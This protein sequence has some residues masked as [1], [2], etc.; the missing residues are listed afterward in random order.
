MDRRGVTGIL[1]DIQSSSYHSYNSTHIEDCYNY[2]SR[3]YT[4]SEDYTI[5]PTT[6]YPTAI[7]T[8]EYAPFYNYHNEVGTNNQNDTNE[9]SVSEMNSRRK[10]QYQYFGWEGYNRSKLT[11]FHFGIETSDLSR[12]YFT[13]NCSFNNYGTSWQ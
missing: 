3:N 11:N 10:Q 2:C 13:D 7:A 6:E 12:I 4:E 9:Q 1:I 8:T 5:S